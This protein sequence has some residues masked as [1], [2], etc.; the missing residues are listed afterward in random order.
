[1]RPRLPLPLPLPLV[2]VLPLPLPL[3]LYH[4]GPLH[5]LQRFNSVPPMA[6]GLTT[7]RSTDGT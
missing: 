6:Q 4:L 3:P 7:A 5:P 1:M 2:V